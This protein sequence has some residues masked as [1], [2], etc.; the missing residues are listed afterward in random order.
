MVE[1]LMNY[2][3]KVKEAKEAKESDLNRSEIHLKNSRTLKR[4]IECE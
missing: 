2:I 3:K 1:E 4:Y